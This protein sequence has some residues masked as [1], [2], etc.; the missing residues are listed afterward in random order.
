FGP[1]K[2]TPLTTAKAT[3]SVIALEYKLTGNVSLNVSY[4]GLA[5]AN[6][7][8]GAQGSGALSLPGST[9]DAATVGATA[10]LADGWQVSGSATM[11]RTHAAYNPLQSINLTHDLDSTA[12]EVVAG[13]QGL[14]GESDMLRVSLTAP[15]HVEGGALEY[16]SMEVVDRST[17][18]IGEVTHSW[19]V[20]GKRE[21]RMEALYR[22]P[23]MDGKG[24]VAAFSLID[25]NP[26]TVNNNVS[27]TIGTR[28]KFGL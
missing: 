8:L 13:K 9:T 22:T 19:N 12:F 21:Y 1:V 3:A 24:E 26:P 10:H 23:I 6:G 25:V 4:T 2:G 14:F 18:E 15:L 16:R 5:E 11:G 7:L 27:L 17:G 28:L 20:S